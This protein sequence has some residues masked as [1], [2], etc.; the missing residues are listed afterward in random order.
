MRKHSFSEFIEASIPI[1][2]VNL[3]SFVLGAEW[4]EATDLMKILGIWLQKIQYQ[5][6]AMK[7]EKAY[8]HDDAKE[9][10]MKKGRQ[11]AAEKQCVVRRKLFL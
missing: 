7:E 9:P 11:A 4:Q 8:K 10:S 5:K 3:L 6:I 1:N 2:P